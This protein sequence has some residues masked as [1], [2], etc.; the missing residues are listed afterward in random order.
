LENLLS[1]DPAAWCEVMSRL[2]P[3]DPMMPIFSY[4]STAAL[5]NSMQ[6]CFYRGMLLCC[7]MQ[8]VFSSR[9]K[10]LT[11]LSLREKKHK[12]TLLL[13]HH[14]RCLGWSESGDLSIA[15]QNSKQ[16]R[17]IPVSNSY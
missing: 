12:Y 5:M 4:F 7:S 14:H 11:F 15:L 9:S 3:L 10:S 2:C 17:H 1:F 8:C 6:W 13:L 16:E